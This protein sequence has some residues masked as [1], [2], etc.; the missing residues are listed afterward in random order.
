MCGIAGQLR[1][2]TADLDAVRRM[3]AALTHR[4]PDGEGFHADGPIAFGHR[5]LSIIDLA[6]GAQPMFNEDRTVCVVANGEIYNYRE[7]R[8][9][10][11]DRHTLRTQS[12]V[13]VLLHL[14]EDF[15]EDFVP[16]L[17]GMFS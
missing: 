12:D 16:R 7:L 5:R 14:Y 11:K 6:G 2:P 3:T 4:G 17:R 9:E 1:F 13:E 10:L 15:G 8:E